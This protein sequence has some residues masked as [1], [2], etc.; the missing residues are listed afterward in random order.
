MTRI[1]SFALGLALTA[2]GCG[3]HISGHG[4]T[5]PK[6]LKTV[7][8]QPFGNNTLRYKLA[9]L[10]PADISRELVSRT[11][12]SLISDPK[13]ADAVLN[14]GL[15][16]Y[17][18]FPIVIDQ[19]TGRATAVQVITI[20][21]ITLTERATGKVLYTRQGFEVRERYEIAGDPAQ[22]FDESG[23]AMERVSK[24]VARAVVS[25]ILEGF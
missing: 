5:M 13:E 19:A 2:T 21:N 3:Y 16:N 8:V 7:A 1:P 23:T 24:D 11:K 20:I 4:D 12:Y 18:A 6:T 10:L 14:G 25:G 9:R 15:V 22:Y 17:F